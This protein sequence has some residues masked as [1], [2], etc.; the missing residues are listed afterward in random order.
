LKR[1]LVTGADGFIGSHLVEHLVRAGWEVRAFVLSN[2]FTSWG[3]L[4][5]CSPDVRGDFEVLAGDIRDAHAVSE[6]ARSCD[7]ILHLAAL[8]GIPYSYSSPASYIETNVSGTLNILQAGLDKEVRRVVHTSTSEVYGSAQFV[9]I[10]ESHPQVGQSPYAASKIGA[11]QLALSFHRSFGAPV[12]IL[13]PFNTYGPRQSA[14]AIIPTV[15]SQLLDDARSLRIGSLTPTRDFSFV[16][17]T[18]RGFVA[19]LTA[20]G[21]EGEVIN[22]GSGFEVSV[23]GLVD[24]IADE[25]GVAPHIEHP[26]ERIRPRTSEV[27]RLLSDNS[28]AQEALNWRPEFEGLEGLR[29]GLRRTI[30]WFSD[31]ANL[32]RYKSTI[33]NT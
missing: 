21:I 29:Q 3:W 25:M 24:L 30:E 4:D 12:S 16:S 1:V 31:P 8:I 2:S 14:R 5:A 22:L 6:A 32:Q 18:V 26:E 9:P 20:R 11:D 13:R 15:I 23:R 28:R 19:A 17:D 27:E 10:T 7:A 33:Y